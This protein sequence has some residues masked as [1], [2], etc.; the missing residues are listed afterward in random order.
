[1]LGPTLRNEYSYIILASS[2]GQASNSACCILL[3]G[4]C[5]ALTW[6]ASA[7]QTRVAEFGFDVLQYQMPEC[8]SHQA[9][10]VCLLLLSGDTILQ[11]SQKD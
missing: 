2:Q 9:L 7:T 4:W 5:S 6:L 1:M 8:S 3:A 10:L 11:R